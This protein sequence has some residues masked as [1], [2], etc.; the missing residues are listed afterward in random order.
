MY[1]KVRVVPGKL[2]EKAARAYLV[3]CKALELPH[4]PSPKHVVDVSEQRRQSRW[5]VSSVVFDPPPQEG[6]DPTGNVNQRQLCLVSDVQ[7]PDLR[8]HGF[9][10]RGT[11]RRVEPTEQHV[12][13]GTPD[14]PRSKAISE[15]IELDVRIRPFAISVL[16]VDDLGFGWMQFQA[17]LYQARL[18]FGLEGVG[19]L[20]VAAVNQSVIRI[21]KPRKVRV[22]P[23]H[24]EIERVMQEQVRQNRAD[25]TTLR[26]ATLSLSLGTVFVLRGRRQPSFDVEPSPF[27]FHVLAD[28]PQ[29]KFVIDGVAQT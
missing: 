13:P 26:G 12:V 19:F 27:A 23:R 22:R 2:F 5:C 11:D 4:H 9:Q 24:P 29:Q 25:N 10:R 3:S 28:S 6:I 21:P 15:K 1:E 14:R 18:K 7:F 8:P 17:A 16:A 20:L